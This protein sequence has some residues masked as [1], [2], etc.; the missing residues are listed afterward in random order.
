MSTASSGGEIDPRKPR[1]RP[2]RHYQ[3]ADN[4]RCADPK[5]N[6]LAQPARAGNCVNAKFV[7]RLTV[8]KQDV[9]QNHGH[10]NLILQRSLLVSAVVAE[11]WDDAVVAGKHG[12][13]SRN[14]FEFSLGGSV[15]TETPLSVLST[16]ITVALSLN[17]TLA[18]S[19]SKL[20]NQVQR[21]RLLR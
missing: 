1:T 15:A 4:P 6:S 18:F 5:R 10:L 16:S 13:S 8:L 21:R 12:M 14:L 3:G 19:W 2:R 17:L 11:M 7:Q 20:N 9:G